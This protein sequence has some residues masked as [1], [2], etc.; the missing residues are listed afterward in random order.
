MQSK[1]ISPAAYLGALPADRR[2]IISA[3]CEVILENLGEGFE[4]G[5]QYGMLSYFVPHAL[6]PPGYHTD[7]QEP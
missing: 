3:V 1:A 6:Y 5:M 7:P 4:E 2:E